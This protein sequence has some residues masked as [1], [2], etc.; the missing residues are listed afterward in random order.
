MSP[1]AEILWMVLLFCLT[2]HCCI[3]TTR[4]SAQDTPNCQ[5]K[6]C[7]PP[8]I[9]LIQDLPNRTLA[10]SST[11]GTP[12]M[13][14][15]LLFSS[16]SGDTH[17]RRTCDAANPQN[18]HPNTA[19]Y[20][21]V[22]S[23]FISRPDL[24]TWWQSENGARDV[25]LTLTLGDS[26]LFQG[27]SLAF[28]SPRP[29]SLFIEKNTDFG[30]TSW[31]PLQYY[32]VSC[33]QTFPTVPTVEG[34]ISYL[35]ICEEIY[36]VGDASTEIPNSNIQEVRYNPAQQLGPDFSQDSV[37][38]YFTVTNIR[39]TLGLPGS[40]VAF[41]NYFA[42]AD[43]E[44]N[45]QCLCFGHAEECRGADLSECV[46]QHNTAGRHCDRCLPLFNNKPWQAA[47]RGQNTANACEECDC[48]GFAVSCIYDATKGH[49]VC[50][51]CAENT[52][53]DNCLRCNDNYFRNPYTDPANND[54][55]V[56]CMCDVNGTQPNTICNEIDGNCT[57][58]LNVQ[59]AH[60][61]EC[62]DTFF[63]LNGLNPVGC[64]PCD[65]DPIGSL[66]STNF[67]D[68][69]TGQCICK[70]NVE[71]SR[72]D[73]CKAG[74]YNLDTANPDGCSL[75]SCDI[76]AS[77]SGQCDGTT[78]ACT[79]RPNI[80]GRACNLT[81]TGYYVPKLDGL[82]YEGELASA[83]KD[84]T[85]E[86]RPTD[87]DTARHTG[88]GFLAVPISTIVTFTDVNIP[89]TQAYEMVLRYES[90]A[91]FPNV[92]IALDQQAPTAYECQG[93]TQSGDT[94]ALPS[95]IPAAGVGGALRFGS[96][97]LNA[98]S[99][100]NISVEIGLSDGGEN[101]IILLDSVVLL[102]VLDDLDV[103]T[104]DMT[105]NLTREVM[106]SCWEAAVIA[107]PGLTV[108]SGECSQYEFSIMAE[109]YN[110]AVAC[111][112]NDAG[113]V[114]GTACDSYSGQCQCIEGVTSQSCDYC[115][116]YHYGYDTVAGCTPCGCDINGAITPSCHETTG[117][118]DCHV[119]VMGA[120]CDACLTEHYGL[121]TGTGCTPCTCDLDYSL[122]N[123]CDDLGQCS[124]KPG[125][126]GQ[127]CTECAPGFYQLTTE[128]CTFC[129][130]DQVGSAQSGCDSAGNC[131][132]SEGTT[133]DKCEACKEGFYGFG[134]WSERG[135]A[136]CY[137]SSHS[138]QC[139]T[140][141]SWFRGQ[142]V[143]SWSLLNFGAVDPRWTGVTG[144]GDS[145]A[146]SEVPILDVSN[147]RLILEL[148]ELSNSTDFFF[149][150]PSVFHGDFRTAYGQS[151]TF[152]LSQSTAQDPS[153][154]PEGDVFIDGTYVDETL[155]AALPYVPNTNMN[156]TEYQFKLHEN[157]WRK[158]SLQGD[159][160]TA[161]FMIKMLAGIR[162]IRIRAKYTTLPGESVF[163]HSAMLDYA[164]QGDGSITGESADFVENCTCPAQYTGLFCE[165]CA[166]GFKRASLDMGPFSDCVPCDCNSHSDLPCHPDTGVCQGCG[167]NTGGEFCELCLDGYYGNATG[168]TPGDCQPC[169]CPGPPGSVNS[170]A[171]VCDDTGVCADCAVGHSGDY[172]Q[173]CVTGYYGV[174]TNTLT[175][176]GQCLPCFCNLSPGDCN[177]ITGE[178]LNCAGNTTGHTCD[179]C[180]FGY[181]GT[182]DNCQACDCDPVGGF[183]NCSR[184]AGVCSC[185][186]N[187]IGDRC[188]QCA[189]DTWGFASGDGCMPCDCHHIGT[190]NQQT[191][192]DLVT[193]Q[194]ECKP[195][196]TG[197]QCDQCQQG[198]WN[199]DQECI[200]CECSLEGTALDT[201][202]VNDNCACDLLTGQCSCK[203]ETIAGRTCNRCGRVD[204]G[205]E[206]VTEVFV[207]AFPNCEPCPE[208]FQDWRRAFQNMA[209]LFR[210]QQM[211][212]RGLLANYNNLTSQEVDNTL[213]FIRGNLSSAAG[214]IEQGTRELVDLEYIQAGFSMIS[215]EVANFTDL[216]TAVETRRLELTTRLTNVQQFTGSVLIQ[217]NTVKTAE[218]LQQDLNALSSTT[219][220][221]FQLGNGTWVNIQ[222]MYAAIEASE[223]GIQQLIRGVDRL[224]QDIER[225]AMERQQ[226]AVILDDE[227]RATEVNQNANLLTTISAIQQDYP[228]AS[229]AQNASAAQQIALEANQSMQGVLQGALI[230]QGQA[231]AQ[232]YRSEMAR[233]NVTNA[234]TA[235]NQAQSAARTYKDLALSTKA[236]MTSLYL[237]VLD[238][239]TALQD[240]EARSVEARTIAR[241]VQDTTVRPSTQMDQ[242]VN[243]INAAPLTA[244]N[245]QN[246]LQDATSK[247]GQAEQTKLSASAG[248]QEAESVGAQLQTI[249]YEL[250]EGER[251]RM[252]TTQRL[253]ETDNNITSIR[254]TASQV[255]EEANQAISSGQQTSAAISSILQ[256]VRTTQQ[257]FSARRNQ[258]QDAAY[259][260]SLA[261]TQAT[262]AQQAYESSAADTASLTS[263][264][265]ATKSQ[266]ST[267]LNDVT[268]VSDQAE[269]LQQQVVT[270]Q[271]M[272]DLDA[273]MTQYMTQREQMQ[274]L[275]GKLEGLE[276]SLDTVLANLD[277]AEGGSLQCNL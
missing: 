256:G 78:G 76:G 255:Q 194:C 246:L 110:G 245:V 132:C 238:T 167:D 107:R 64:Q 214:A 89:R 62:K 63:N 216:V 217:E 83:D 37:T 59:N 171:S 211:I 88:R 12:P 38:R 195:R 273:L 232:A 204:E 20:D 9:D 188:M 274:E 250:T 169:L 103:F 186:P 74:S 10:V 276:A 17:E 123:A 240:A 149:A 227:N 135:C 104:S 140:A 174:P 7:Y 96:A 202:D 56:A 223:Q 48:N 29:Q 55:C 257:C 3:H 168:G 28:R 114:P 265:N 247:L 95:N 139:S 208:C 224:L 72:C 158:G 241:A 102:P 106:T 121:F 173:T 141:L 231:D 128:G 267:A 270:V 166:P 6:A 94:I 108:D 162:S 125:I 236:N 258:A 73:T 41:R 263:L 192:C 175:N 34:V 153:V 54:T 178:C 155:V 90:A 190:V 52:G 33:S 53:G 177:T 18:A 137:C 80:A 253:T 127:S 275:D 50:Q 92:R 57:C 68:K 201:C 269:T 118:C 143:S 185:Y 129:E 14:Y 81:V 42:V 243:Q 254:S 136:R 21:S 251:V 130:C 142:V 181:W 2:H 101:A 261:G 259:R 46:C 157:Y 197:Q 45:G 13:D 19:L 229:T 193:G 215:A 268:V 249:E 75:C 84:V 230:V 189:V 242:L 218:Q 200:A 40:E 191:Q 179:I 205:S 32:A 163:L 16:S 115:A 145:V 51:D 67:C 187:V 15:E 207:G 117:A 144:T 116:A 65:C 70:S 212:L 100:Y 105:S 170:F 22:T 146:I 264:I 164:M 79:C 77:L 36:V 71:G 148:T 61:D 213:D 226:A 87:T 120:K 58:K 248:Q 176:N 165:S 225:A 4:V 237:Q 112:C 69:V 93:T 206:I 152:T 150:S 180:D 151:L 154:N 221:L 11:C 111:S 98:A 147:P 23:F 131:L 66:G 228:L 138:T 119:N 113:T 24:T 47:V 239:Y 31:L 244:S 160:P 182:I 5:N 109:V 49:G 209:D 234:D 85:I 235:A 262:T 27:T 60:C 126:G 91:N 124:C 35:P 161:E 184:D 8:F 271:Q 97:C 183:G 82:T 233:F 99:Q 203:S 199:I 39:V 219:T 44:V 210:E 30:R 220:A 172:C 266:S 159:Q 277:S 198:Y 122:D 196:V 43:W 222:G 156:E 1:C 25:Q 86:E 272:A 260:A 134:P 26:F 133:G 252:E